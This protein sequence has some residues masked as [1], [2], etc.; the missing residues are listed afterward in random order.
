[1]RRANKIGARFIEKL[2]GR[3]IEFDRHMTALIHIGMRDTRMPNHERRRGLG[4]RSTA[5]FEA[6]TNAP[7]QKLRGVTDSDPAGFCSLIVVVRQPVQGVAR[8]THKGNK[9]SRSSVAES[10]KPAAP[11]RCNSAI[12][13]AP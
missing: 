9:S 2:T 11:I 8:E 12:G 10:Q 3:K 6:D 5:P 7:L 1:M 4:L 13:W